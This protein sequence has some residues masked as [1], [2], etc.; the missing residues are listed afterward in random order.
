MKK[1]GQKNTVELSV[2]ELI[3]LPATAKV[4][5]SIRWLR[6]YNKF[7]AQMG[8]TPLATDGEDSPE[9]AEAPAKGGVGNITVG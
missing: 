7:A 9:T 3:K 4:T 2:G 8:M 6:D 5:V 1:A